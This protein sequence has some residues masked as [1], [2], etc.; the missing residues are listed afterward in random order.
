MITSINFGGANAARFG[1]TNNC[2]IRGAGLAA[3]ASCTINVV[4]TPNNTATRTATLRVN[5]S[6]PAVSGTVTLTGTTV[7]PMVSVSPATIP[8]GSQA[9]NTTSLEQTVTFTNTGVVP[10]VISRISLG[11]VNPARFAI[12]KNTC[13]IGG[14][15]VAAGGSCTVSVTFRPTRKVSYSATLTFRDNANPGSQVVSL[16]GSGQ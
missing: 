8:F 5:V 13:P 3:G 15:G 11:G 7:R 12:T 16:T 1:Q 6:A 4:F 9:I 2:P 10:V 14:T